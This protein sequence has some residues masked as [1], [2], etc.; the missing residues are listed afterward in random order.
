MPPQLNESSKFIPAEISDMYDLN[1]IK[2]TELS[3]HL[4]P[5]KSYPTKPNQKKWDDK[6]SNFSIKDEI[7][8][9]APDYSESDRLKKRKLS[10]DYSLGG[11]YGQYPLVQKKR[12]IFTN[13]RYIENETDA[14]A[15]QI[16]VKS[17]YKIEKSTSLFYEKCIIFCTRTYE[18]P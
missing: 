10:N 9:V 5:T 8:M 4:L 3:L 1:P 14:N 6:T 12:K 11:D 7:S 15:I 18:R 17:R 2:D 13:R 16:N